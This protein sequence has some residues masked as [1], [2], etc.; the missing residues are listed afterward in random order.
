MRPESNHLS[1]RKVT[2]PLRSYEEWDLFKYSDPALDKK[3]IHSLSS[4]AER[5]EICRGKEERLTILS[6][7]GIA[8]SVV[9][10]KQWWF[11]LGGTE[12]PQLKHLVCSHGSSPL[13]PQKKSCYSLDKYG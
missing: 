4:R 2:T 7:R 5:G 1:L 12:P 6:I 11:F 8:F 3:T 10:G 13:Q 9:L